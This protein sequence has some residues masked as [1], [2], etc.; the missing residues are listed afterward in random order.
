MHPLEGMIYPGENCLRVGRTE[1]RDY[2]LRYGDTLLSQKLAF[3]RDALRSAFVTR[4]P[5]RASGRSFRAE[6]FLTLANPGEIGPR[7]AALKEASN[8][9]LIGCALD[10]EGGE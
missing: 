3:R 6:Q 5:A 8:W 9:R 7:A 2:V 4:V 10:R 1:F